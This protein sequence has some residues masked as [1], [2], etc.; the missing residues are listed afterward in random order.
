M[1]RRVSQIDRIRA[2]IDQRLS[3]EDD[4]GGFLKTSPAWA[5][6]CCSPVSRRPASSG[7]MMRDRGQRPV[8]YIHD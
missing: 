2:E 5:P 3:A 7:K 1:R 4:L 6:A 8:T